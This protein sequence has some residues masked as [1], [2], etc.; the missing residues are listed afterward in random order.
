M[1]R[2]AVYTRLSH[3]P[4]GGEQ[5]ATARQRTACLTFAELRGWEVAHVYEDV[6]LSAFKRGVV[7][8]DYEH[9]LEAVST[10][11]VDGVLVWKLDRL[12]RRPAE[13]ERFWTTCE[14]RGAF[15]A[16]VTEPIDR[17]G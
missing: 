14:R 6:E 9:M 3:D 10:G 5:T 11:E 16:S 1:R 8:P 17:G 7:R 13:F 12:M 2:V 15:L 4:T